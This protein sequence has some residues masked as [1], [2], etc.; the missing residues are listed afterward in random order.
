MTAKKVLGIRLKEL[1]SS[2]NKT[3]E[4]IAKELGITRAAYSHFENDRNEPDFATLSKLANY[5]D[6]STDYLVGNSDK[7]HYYSLTDKD[8][9]DI[10]EQAQNIINGLDTS[11]DVNFYGEPMTDEQK[12]SMKEIIEM[13]L[14]I[15]QEKAKKKFTPK[16]YR[17]GE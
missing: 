13:G 1:R 17:H 6:V 14:R 12:A 16:K 5:Y 4:Q 2:K 15:N 9:L 7:K 11:A 3:Q 10:A 8:N